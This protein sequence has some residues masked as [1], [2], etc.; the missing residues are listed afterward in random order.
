MLSVLFLSGC[1]L[2]P[3]G[4]KASSDWKST[5]YT[6]QQ[7]EEMRVDSPENCRLGDESDDDCTKEAFKAYNVML[8]IPKTLRILSIRYMIFI[9]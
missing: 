6:V 4:G 7:I 8:G 5:D 2:L 1:S 3:L 9:M